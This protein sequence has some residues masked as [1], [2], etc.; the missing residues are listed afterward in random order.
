[1][2]PASR[3]TAS[4]FCA[5][6]NSSSKILRSVTSSAIASSTSAGSS[7]LLTARPLTR[8]VTARPSFRFHRTSIPSIRPVRRNSSI[9]RTWS[10]GFT[11]T[12]RRGSNASTSSADS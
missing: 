11:N 8:T 9:S 5:C 6:R 12:S 1:M 10:S 4:I 2:P 7:A 3:P